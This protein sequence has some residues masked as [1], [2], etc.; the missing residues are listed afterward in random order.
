MKKL[1]IYANCQGIA[2]GKTLLEDERFRSLYE[3][4]RIEP[5]QTLSSSHV[6][7]ISNSIA[8]AD[9]IIY[10]PVSASNRAEDLSTQK[11]LQQSKDGVKQI[12]IPS[13]YFDGYFPHLSTMNG[14]SSILNLVHD[15]FIAYA[16]CRG[17][18]LENCV[19][20]L[21]SKHLYEK[22]RSV[23][24]CNASIE[25][26][27]R[28]ENV[29]KLD[30]PISSFIE[31]NYKK[32]KLF[33]QFNHP[34]RR[35]FEYISAQVCEKI[36]LDGFSPDPDAGGYL[37]AISTPIYPSTYQNLDLQFEENFDLY[38]GRKNTI[39]SQRDVVEKFYRFYS[40]L[41]ISDVLEAVKSKKPFVS[42][43]VNEYCLEKNIYA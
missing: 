43:M 42:N 25:N 40:E 7:A 27:R 12:S 2:L 22:T 28:R 8:E 9:L 15:Y 29:N 37:D 36:G 20:M 10:Q 31:Q 5:V 17:M 34:T 13:M 33:N 1:T 3:W 4:S 38:S 23:E 32:H 30:I 41:E 39:W 6:E 35:M 26:L 16:Y 19:L 24:L 21:Q 18:S 14:L 11:I